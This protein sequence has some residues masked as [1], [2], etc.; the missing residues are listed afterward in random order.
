MKIAINTRFLLPGALEGFGWYTHEI[1]SRMVKN[2]PEDEFFFFFDRPFDRRFIYAENVTPVVLFPPAR[3]PW[4][5]RWWFEH[6][7]PAALKRCGAEVFFS[8]D[9][10]CSLRSPV[11]TVMTCHDLAPLHFPEQ[12]EARHRAYLLKYLPKWLQRADHVLTVSHYVEEDL[13]KNCRIPPEKLTAVYNGCRETFRPLPAAEQQLVRDAYSGGQP[14]FFFAGAIHPRKNVHQ[15]IRAYDLFRAASND[16]VKLLLAGRFAWQ[17]G[18]IKAAWE[19]ATFREDVRFLGYL[20]DTELPRLMAA[21]LA[22]VY[23]SQEEGF[24]LPLVEAM[25]SE[26]PVI[27]SNVSC[28]PEIAGDAALLVN[29]IDTGDMARAMTRIWQEPALRAQLVEKGLIRKTAFDWQ[30]A[31][32]K[33][34]DILVNG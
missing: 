26:T 13:K 25:A 24:G 22:M 18:V 19:Q 10:M 21:A 23:P 8:P 4:L 9:S 31:A 27:T 2:H 29:P 7:V 33:I 17:T 1:A 34:Y 3:H 30:P 16:G 12:I 28:L 11:R 15:I 32:D 6:S 14:F 5:F 20:D